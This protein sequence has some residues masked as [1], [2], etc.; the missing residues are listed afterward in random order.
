[1][2]ARDCLCAKLPHQGAMCL[3]DT[4][5]SWDS[6]S[7]VCTATS[8]RDPENP[9]RHNGH[10]AAIHAVEYAGQAA[11]LHGA[12]TCP[13]TD[14]DSTSA[15]LAA[16]NQ[17]ELIQGNLDQLPAPLLIG[18]WRELALGPSVIYRFL[19]ECDELAVARGRLTVIG[20]LR[21]QSL[22]PP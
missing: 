5:R 12:L 15:L 20:G 17:V 21:L 13:N 9:L 22:G 7:I 18:A 3:L 8:H 6:V 2:L 1:M 11:A 4:L 19:I 10:L 14:D 16:V